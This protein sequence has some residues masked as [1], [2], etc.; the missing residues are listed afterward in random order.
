MDKK[1]IVALSDDALD[2]ISGGMVV[3][4]D[5]VIDE[6]TGLSYPI[7][8]PAIQ[9]FSFLGQLGNATEET[10]LNALREAGMID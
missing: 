6:D 3:K 1:N 7:K 8:V 9:V 10:R 2:M 4:R 5:C